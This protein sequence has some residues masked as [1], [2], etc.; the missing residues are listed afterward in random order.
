MKIRKRCR[1]ALLPYNRSDQ[2]DRTLI[3][4][5]FMKTESSFTPKQ[6]KIIGSLSVAVLLGFFTVLYFLV[7]RPMMAFAS[8][9]EKFSAWI[10]EKGLVGKLAFLGMMIFQVV[11]AVIPAE[12]LEIGAGY[13]FGTWGGAFWCMLGLMAGSSIVFVLVR[14]FGIRLVEVF[15]SVEK[16]NS[17]SF[18]RDH[19]RL[20]LLT[21]L[22]YFI[23][24]T[25][26]D[27]ITYVSCLTEIPF[28]HWLVLSSA[29]RFLSVI[30][31]TVGGA[32]LQERRYLYAGIVFAVTVLVSAIGLLIYRKLCKK[33][34]GGLNGDNDRA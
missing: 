23:P 1:F 31:S 2:T 32:A 19:R 12:P 24:G 18:L 5:V 8:D 9:P 16:I 7:G 25:P 26:K 4:E 29:G 21:F 11:V 20:E 27:L 14:R 30:T 17:L 3:R 10:D 6:K 33:Q 15:F 13:A 22:L 34:G 28:L